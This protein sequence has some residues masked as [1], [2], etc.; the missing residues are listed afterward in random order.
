MLERSWQRALRCPSACEATVA[1]RALNV[2]T[3][4]RVPSVRTMTHRQRNHVTD[5]R[6]VSRMAIDATSGL[7]DLVESLQ[8]RIASGPAKAGGP[9]V[10]GAIHGISD[11]VYGTIRGVTRVV[12]SGIDAVLEQLSPLLGSMESS[13]SRDALVA[14][15]NGVL[16]DYLVETHNPLALDMQFR[17]AGRVLELTPAALAA[18]ISAPRKQLLVLAHGLCMNDLQWLRDG[19]D[20]GAALARDLGLTPVYLRYNTGLHISTNGAA[21]AQRLEALVGAWPEPPDTLVFIGHSVGGLMARSAFHYGTAAGHTWPRKLR[22][23]VFLGTPHHGAPL[24]R[25]GQWIDV[26]LG[27]TPYTEPFRRL[28]RARSAG[29]TDLRH[30]CLLDEDWQGRDRFAHGEDQRRPL[31]LPE[32]VACFAIAGHLGAGKDEKKEHLL[33]D[34]LVPI[35]S[36]LG[37]HPDPRFRLDFAPTRQWIAHDTGHLD[38]LSSPA[39]YAHIRD[40]LQS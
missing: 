29:I 18:A 23:L 16:G 26:L 4:S 38:L 22:K 2:P 7:V 11:L 13:R 6:G 37:Q 30:G 1:A 9:I 15:L 40:W 21:F 14:A 39:V 5:L 34:G 27:A 10:E 8:K 20:H 35:A 25:G 36:A 28:G 31:P 3:V 12:G 33:G 32:G 19:H 24:E 17:R